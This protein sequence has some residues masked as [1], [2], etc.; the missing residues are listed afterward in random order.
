[1]ATIGIGIARVNAKAG[2][3]FVL[4]RAQYN[5]QAVAWCHLRVVSIKLLA[6]RGYPF[7]PT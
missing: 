6:L 2:A 3:L 7:L 5:V 1:M 4:G